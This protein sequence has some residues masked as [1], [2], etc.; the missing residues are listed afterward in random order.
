MWSRQWAKPVTVMLRLNLRT[1]RSIKVEETNATK[2]AG[3]LQHS[4]CS[5]RI[6][7]HFCVSDLYEIYRMATLIWDL[8][9]RDWSIE[10][11]LYRGNQYVATKRWTLQASYICWHISPEP[12]KTVSEI[13]HDCSPVRRLSSAVL[14]RSVGNK[15]P[16]SKY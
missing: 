3:H 10:M 16:C 9:I 11:K 13:G 12:M 15:D 7:L 1:R 6:K 2:Q 4:R 8:V 14:S 5:K